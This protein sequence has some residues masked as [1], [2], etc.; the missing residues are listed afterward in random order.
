MKNLF[1]PMC[2]ALFLLF[3]TTVSKA[4]DTAKGLIINTTS[5]AEVDKIVASLK[6][7]DPATYRLTVNY[8]AAPLSAVGKVGGSSVAVGA[9]GVAASDVIL[10]VK[11]ITTGKDLQNSI[12]SKLNSSLTK[13]SFKSVKASALRGGGL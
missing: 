9:G 5:Q 1:I 11:V 3:G 2:A 8:G 6:G 13:Q 7:A 12:I 10:A 4:Q